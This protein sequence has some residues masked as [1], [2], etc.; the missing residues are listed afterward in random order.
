MHGSPE[1]IGLQTLVRPLSDHSNLSLGWRVWRSRDQCD[2]ELNTKLDG[3]DP[4]LVNPS[5]I[6]LV[7]RSRT[8]GADW[9]VAFIWTLYCDGAP[10]YLN[11]GPGP[12]DCLN[13]NRLHRWTPRQEFCQPR[14]HLL[15]SLRRVTNSVTLLV[16]TRTKKSTG[17]CYICALN[18]ARTLKLVKVLLPSVTHLADGGVRG[19]SRST[20]IR[21]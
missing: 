16:L 4:I 18:L 2:K 9:V 5:P 1:E 10:N 21:V 11:L 15:S 3:C 19:P 12:K 6:I 7:E 13:L 17:N 20:C 8:G 14:N